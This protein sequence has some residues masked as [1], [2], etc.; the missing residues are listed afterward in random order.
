[1]GAKG[2]VFECGRMNGCHKTRIKP[3]LITHYHDIIQKGMLTQ[4]YVGIEWTVINKLQTCN[5]LRAFLMSPLARVIKLCIPSLVH[6]TLNRTQHINTCNHII[7][8]TPLYVGNSEWE[9]LANCDLFA[10]ILLA[11]L[12]AVENVSVS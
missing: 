5:I 9:K 2:M 7:L 4:R 12:I 11:N 1:M 3:G 10:N 6:F 8:Y